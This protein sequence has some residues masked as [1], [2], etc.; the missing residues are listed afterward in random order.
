MP[1][2]ATALLQALPLAALH[3]ALGVTA[4]QLAHTAET[5]TAEQQAEFT[6]CSQ[7]C[8]HFI[9][10]YVWTYDP[11]HEAAPNHL[12]FRLY[13]FQADLLARLES[14]YQAGKFQDF[15]EKSRDMGISWLVLAW[16]V[17]HWRFDSSFQALIGSRTEDLVDQ[18]DRPDTMMWK[19]RYILDRLPAWLR[20]AGF[21]WDTHHTHL[22]VVNPENG[23][24]I[25][26]QSSNANF[27]RQGRYSVVVLDEFQVWS[28][29][30]AAWTAVADASPCR[31][32]ICTA[33]PGSFA[34]ELRNS[35]QIPVHSIHWRLHPH[36]DLNWYKAQQAERTA[37]SIAKELDLNWS[38]A[39][40]GLVYPGWQHIPKGGYPFEL[41]WPLY[42]TWDFGIADATAL[43][44]WQ[45]NPFSRLWRIVDCVASSGHAIDWYVPFVTGQLPSGAGYDYTVRQLEQIL[46]HMRWPAAIHFG[47]PAGEQRNVATGESAASRLRD[48]HQIYIQSMPDANT[49]EQRY[50]ATQLF[51]RRVEGVN[52]PA[53]NLLDDAMSNA[54]FPERREG[55]QATSEITKPIHDWTSHFRT[56]IEYMAVNEP[57]S[58]LAVGNGID[59][60]QRIML[61]Q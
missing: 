59:T 20:P 32:V 12:P 26:G 13:P 16:L 18:A 34:K 42:V 47:D 61:A 21:D 39:L 28:W 22:L 27:S 14:E 54:R 53:C 44:W 46:R 33:E 23:N 50:T 5:R 10:N 57:V 9:D 8:R 60:G 35:G 24:S 4:D 37:E 30:R 17:W 29:A 48:Q 3:V 45:R 11:R 55:S 58:S 52:T 7:S 2:N 6:A 36:K 31:L 15:W 43:V 38:G 19:L 1:A 56:T 41:D 40:R 25:A 49:F 51:L